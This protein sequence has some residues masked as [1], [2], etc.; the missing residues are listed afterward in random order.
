[1]PIL[2]ASVPLSRSNRGGREIYKKRE[3]KKAAKLRKVKNERCNIVEEGENIFEHFRFTNC[4]NSNFTEEK[5][6]ALGWLAYNSLSSFYPV[7]LCAPLILLRS[8]AARHN[9]AVT[10]ANK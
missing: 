5:R 9:T 7:L 4:Y 3:K 2:A 10:A 1:M 8:V 6:S